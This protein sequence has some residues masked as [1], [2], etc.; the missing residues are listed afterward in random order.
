MITIFEK[1]DSDNIN[2][3]LIEK[4]AG[5]LR[6]GGLVAFP[7]VTVYGLG[8]DGLNASACKKIYE[9]KRRPTDNPLIP[10]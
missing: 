8:A 10:P 7:T 5:I 9:A 1:I 4:A 2:M 3:D 6:K